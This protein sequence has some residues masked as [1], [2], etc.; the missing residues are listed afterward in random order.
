MMF[1]HSGSVKKTPKPINVIRIGDVMAP[2]IANVIAKKD[3]KIWP[4][5]NPTRPSMNASG[6]NTKERTN[7][8]TNPII[9][10]QMP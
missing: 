2:K 6:D 10:P 7:I 9:I 3:E 5:N 1:I 4:L 8:P